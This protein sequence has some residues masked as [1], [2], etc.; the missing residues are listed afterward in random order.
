MKTTH[1]PVFANTCGKIFARKVVLATSTSEKVLEMEDIRQMSFRKTTPVSGLLFAAL[2]ALLIIVAFF[3][4]KEDT[5]LKVLLG[6][7][8]TIGVVVSL[9]K[10]KKQHTLVVKT[11][12]GQK[13]TISVWE[14]NAK[15]AAKFADKV[16]GMLK[17]VKE[18]GLDEET[19]AVKV[20]MSAVS[21]E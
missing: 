9:L 21:A 19:N 2:P 18:A 8:G 6:I 1:Q 13:F 3:L 11:A 4:P 7:L 5:F 14:G 12:D 17:T 15:E 10:A 16:N 20:E